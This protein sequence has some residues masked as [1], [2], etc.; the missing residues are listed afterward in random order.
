MDGEG[1]RIERMASGGFMVLWRTDI[2]RKPAQDSLCVTTWFSGLR[3]NLRIP[4]ALN[5]NVLASIVSSRGR[6]RAQ[7]A[8]IQFG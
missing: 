6:A 3:Q 5:R 4:I 7:R 1:N 2:R 8:R